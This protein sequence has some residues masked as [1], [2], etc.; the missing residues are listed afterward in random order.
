MTHEEK[1]VRNTELLPKE[2]GV[3]VALKGLA[4]RL[5]C[6]GTQHKSIGLKSAYTVRERKENHLLMLKNLQGQEPNGLCPGTKVLAEATFVL[7]L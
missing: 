6:P 1:D 2:Q 4:W 5:T 3:Y 7:C